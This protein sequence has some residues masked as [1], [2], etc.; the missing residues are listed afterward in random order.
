MAEAQPDDAVM[1]GVDADQLAKLVGEASDEQIAQGMQSENRKQV[2]DEIFKRM[3]DHVEPERARDTKAVVHFKIL[4]RPAGGCD[5]YEVVLENGTCT[6]S[7]SPSRE[8]RV[9]FKIPPVEFIRLVSG[10]ASGPALFMTGKL[11]IEGDVMFAAQLT[12]LFKVPGAGG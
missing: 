11:K 10:N 7:D 12:S 5:H 1:S 3:A 2:L 4:D 6:A 8:A 9:T